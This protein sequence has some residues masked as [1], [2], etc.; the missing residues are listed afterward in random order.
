M[1]N[2]NNSR[3]AVLSILTISKACGNKC[4]FDKRYQTGKIISQVPVLMIEYLVAVSYELYMVSHVLFFG[5]NCYYS[6]RHDREKCYAYVVK[7]LIVQKRLVDSET[8]NF[9]V[10]GYFPIKS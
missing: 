10:K 4:Y 1:V 7:G 3:T 2:I 5:F 8:R 9:L 6:R